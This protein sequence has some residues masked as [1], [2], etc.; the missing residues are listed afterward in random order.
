MNEKIEIF[1]VDEEGILI[2][3]HMAED[4]YDFDGDPEELESPLMLALGQY[5]HAQAPKTLL[6]KGFKTPSGILYWYS[7]VATPFGDDDDIEVGERL[8]LMDEYFQRFADEF[9]Y[10]SLSEGITPLG[11]SPLTEGEEEEDPED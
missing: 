8:Y 4:L 11:W 2:R 9:A 10:I 7:E 1:L 5:Y 6:T 3:V